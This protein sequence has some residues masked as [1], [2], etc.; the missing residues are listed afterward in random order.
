M[1]IL[2]GSRDDEAEADAWA[3]RDE[4]LAEW[5]E[6]TLVNR[7]DVHGGQRIDPSGAMKRYTSHDWREHGLPRV[8]DLFPRKH[9]LTGKRCGHWLRLPGRH[10]KRP[11]WT[12][13]WSPARRLWRTGDAAIDALL[14]LRGKPV[15][16]TA[17]V[18]ADFRI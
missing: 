12:R 3:A 6:R 5:A 4:E 10:H 14:S 11:H 16:V 1:T 17:I 9:E 15:D 8:P 7:R 2:G 18:P 13:V